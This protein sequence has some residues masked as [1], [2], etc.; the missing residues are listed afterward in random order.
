MLTARTVLSGVTLA[1]VVAVAPARAA[2]APSPPAAPASARE[3]SIDACQKHLAALQ[4]I[5]AA[6]A[7][8]RDR[9]SCDP[10][11]VGPDDR[12]P[13]EGSAE[14]R[15]IRY[16]WLRALLLKAQVREE[17]EAK[18]ASAAKANQDEAPSSPTTAELLSAAG[19][20]LAAEMAQAEA[21]HE[22]AASHAP[23]RAEMNQVLAGREFR[24]LK[25]RSVRD[26]VMEKINEWL[27]RL[28]ASAGKLRARSAWVGRVVVWGFV[29]AVLVGLAWSLL[30]M[31]RRWRMR[32]TPE[33][34]G[35]GTG[36]ASARGWQTWLD[37]A[38]RSAE[39]G[40]WREAIHAVYWAAIARLESRRLWPA[41]RARTPREYLALVAED[42]PRK[43]GLARLTASFERTW[44]GGRAAAESDYRA[45]EERAT[46]LMEG[47]GAP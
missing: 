25:E 26:V 38:Q 22:A 11:L 19:K 10:E 6:C 9:R 20:R 14:R 31:E 45:A 8:A 18:P 1:V 21:P 33:S 47:G 43:A 5:V 3:A 44:Y 7:R 2:T 41:D 24:H 39:G 30:Q 37:D 15:L 29:L 32:L 16:A 28:F 17:A 4:A 42:D 46:A 13:L 35:P 40:Q 27:N 36:T 34:E 23:E 12:I